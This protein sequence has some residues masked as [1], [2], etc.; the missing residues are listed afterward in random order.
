MEAPNKVRYSSIDKQ[1]Q[2]VNTTGAACNT[3]G[4]NQM[5]D[6]AK[7]GKKGKINN[8]KLFQSNAS[9]S[10]STKPGELNKCGFSKNNSL[11]FGAQVATPSSNI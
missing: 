9:Q 11:N 4:E 3:I 5:K 10:S 8:T 1:I 7:A 2:E 6:F